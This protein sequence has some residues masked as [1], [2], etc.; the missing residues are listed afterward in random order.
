[1]A[2]RHPAGEQPP[3]AVIGNR[4]E[5]LAVVGKAQQQPC[6]CRKCHPGRSGRVFV[7]VEKSAETVMAMDA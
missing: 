5:A 3:V 2:G 6:T 4:A 7:L 1:M